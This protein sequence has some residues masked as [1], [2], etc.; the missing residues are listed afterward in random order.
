MKGLSPLFQWTVELD[1][2]IVEHG[3]RSAKIVIYANELSD[4][5]LKIITAHKSLLVIGT[6]RDK[7]FYCRIPLWFKPKKYSARMKNGI[8]TISVRGRRFLFF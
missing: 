2:D 4:G 1:Y 6:A 3:F 7:S 5:N 8:L